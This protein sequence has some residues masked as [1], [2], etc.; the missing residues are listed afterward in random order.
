MDNQSPHSQGMAQVV[1][2]REKALDL[3]QQKRFDDAEQIYVE[4]LKDLPPSFDLHLDYVRFKVQQGYLVDA[5]K[6]LDAMLSLWPENSDI[7]V[8]GG[9]ICLSSP[10]FYEV[11]ADW[12]D[13][14]LRHHPRHEQLIAQ[15]S[16]WI[17]QTVDA[18]EPAS[19]AAAISEAPEFSTPPSETPAPAAPPP[20]PARDLSKISFVLGATQHGPMIFS[21]LDAN[22]VQFDNRTSAY[23]VGFQLM[24]NGQ[25]D[26]DEVFFLKQILRH[27]LEYFKDGVVAIDCGANIGVHTIEWGRLMRGWG[28]VISFEAQDMI[29][30]ALAGNVALNNLM[31]VQAI[32]AAVGDAVGFLKIPRPD[33][34]VNSSFGSLELKKSRKNENIGQPIDYDK[35]LL[36]VRAVTI[37]AFQLPRVDLIKIDVEGMEEQALAGASET[38]ERCKP[39]LCVEVLKSDRAKI[40]EFIGAFGYKIFSTG[41]NVVAIHP[42]DPTVK[43]FP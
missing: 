30:Y 43:K 22:Y 23:G 6:G 31:N 27:R 20:A 39:V 25:Y 35:G 2:C 9:E 5:L 14:A 17:R 12:F 15:K 8:L 42:S 38:I 26:E 28:S 32:H 41:L 40:T 18:G 13:E 16:K 29:F 3:I 11:G 1:L 10:E 24:E 36:D 19:A 7:W 37:D 33:Y 4:A 34:M 21:R